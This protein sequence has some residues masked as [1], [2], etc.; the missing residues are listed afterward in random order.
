MQRECKSSEAGIG[1]TMTSFSYGE[2]SYG[3]RLI[4]GRIETDG[5]LYEDLVTSLFEIGGVAAQ[6]VTGLWLIDLVGC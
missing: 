1:I 4:V 2:F 5:S 3:D 6:F